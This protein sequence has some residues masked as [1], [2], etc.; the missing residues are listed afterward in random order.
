MLLKYLLL[1]LW[2]AGLLW[3]CANVERFKVWQLGLFVLAFSAML[4]VIGG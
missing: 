2:T 4:A 1:V 3:T